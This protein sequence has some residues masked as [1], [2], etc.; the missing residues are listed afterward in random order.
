M[1]SATDDKYVQINRTIC[2]LLIC[3]FQMFSVAR[4]QAPQLQKTVKRIW[5]LAQQFQVWAQ[6]IDLIILQLSLIL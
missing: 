5:R 1:P 4:F 2:A 6:K 3:T